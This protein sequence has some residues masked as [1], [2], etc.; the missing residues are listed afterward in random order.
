MF[1]HTL[2]CLLLL[3]C[4]TCLLA[5]TTRQLLHSSDTPTPHT[6]AWLAHIQIGDTLKIR[7][8]GEREPLTIKVKE[9]N[10]TYI[11]SNED[12]KVWIDAITSVEKVE[13]SWLKTTLLVVGILL[14]AAAASI[15]NG[16]DDM[17]FGC[18]ANCPTQ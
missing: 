3:F 4:C 14:V 6:Q 15:K 10:N 7:Q 16:M 11:L 1:R 18:T 13:R 12:T 17:D 9:I 5:C 2:K 8:T